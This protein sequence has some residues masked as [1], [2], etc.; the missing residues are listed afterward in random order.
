[1]NKPIKTRTIVLPNRSSLFGKNRFEKIELE[2]PE[3]EKIWDTYGEDQIEA[4]YVLTTA[5][6]ERLKN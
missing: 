6:M 5:F 3:F 4:R 1:M 2:D